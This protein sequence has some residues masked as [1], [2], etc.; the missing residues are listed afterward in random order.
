MK[1]NHAFYKW[2]TG[3]NHN[4]PAI[5]AIT[6]SFPRLFVSSI[7]EHNRDKKLW[8]GKKACFTLSFDCDYPEDVEALPGLLKMLSR[9]KFKAS[10][11]AVGAWIEKYP[12][13]HLDVLA[14]GHEIVNH[15]YSHPDNELLNPGR[16]FLEIPYTDKKAE[17]EKCHEICRKVLGY[18]P[19]GCR[20]PH[21]KTLFTPEIYDILADLNYAY[22]SSTWLTNTTTSG[23]PFRAKNEII[24]FPVSVCPRHPFTV[25]DTWHSLHPQRLAHSIVHKGPADYFELF[26]TL[27]DFGIKTGSYLNIYIDPLD[28][29]HIP[30]FEAILEILS[31]DAILVETYA[32]YLGNKLHINEHAV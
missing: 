22:S 32:G 10:F 6:F 14:H 18:E 17:I 25:F 29:K 20:I 3:Q 19:A 13:Q 16:R 21:F 27:I 2:I 31:D 28:V 26:K 23:L 1:I 12:R 11:A 5:G 9:Y 4:L 15:T 30:S 8:N 24:E 7:Y